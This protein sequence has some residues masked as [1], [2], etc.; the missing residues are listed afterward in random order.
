MSFAERMT[1][2]LVNLV[3]KIPYILLP[4]GLFSTMSIVHEIKTNDKNGLNFW[5]G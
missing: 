2:R 3:H 5:N 4:V 1:L